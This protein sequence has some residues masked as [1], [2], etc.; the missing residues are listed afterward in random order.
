M[1]SWQS[2]LVCTLLR[3][4]MKRASGKGVD[5]AHVRR[6]FGTPNNAALKVWPGWR[7][8]ALPANRLM[9]ET[10]EQ[11]TGPALRDDLAV[12]YLHGGGYFFGSPQ[13]HRQL[14]LN[15]AKHCNAPLFSL[16]Y[17]LAPEHHFPAALDDAV[18]GYRWLARTYPQKRIVIAGDSAGGGLALCT[19]LELRNGAEHLPAAIVVFSPWTD[20]AC[21]GASL[22][23]NERRCAMF[24]AKGVRDAARYYV[25]DADPRD[26]RISP[27]YA[28]LEGLPPTQI[29]ASTD[30]VLL[31]D[32]L[33]FADAARAANVDIELQL[34]TGVPHIWPIFAHLIPEGRDS[35]Q[36]VARFV[37][38]TVPP[39]RNWP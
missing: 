3:L 32:S 11:A 38:R 39:R 8:D 17:R 20:L 23:R 7:V 13:T 36:Q 9:F 26:P 29:F 18:A 2:F 30:E 5:I 14:A 35:L 22:Q 15:L 33:R 24:T 37:A 27:L 1:A 10:V 4:T 6:T 25:G 28:N 16:D 12:F 34:R 31:D 21:V 19:A